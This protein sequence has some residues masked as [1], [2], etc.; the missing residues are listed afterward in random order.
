MKVIDYG[1]PVDGGISGRSVLTLAATAFQGVARLVANVAIGRLGDP[2]LLGMTQSAIASGNIGSLLFAS[3]ASAAA[4][5]NIAFERAKQERERAHAVAVHLSRRSVAASVVIGL[6]AASVQYFVTGDLVF[7][8]AVLVLCVTSSAYALSRGLHLGAGEIGRLATWEIGIATA[9]LIGTAALLLGGVRSIWVVAP[10][11]VGHV[12]MAAFAWPR[13][14]PKQ[15][16]RVDKRSIRTFVLLGTI[17]TLSSAGF[18]QLAIIW[19][20]GLNGPAYAGQMTAALSMVGPA[21]MVAGAISQVLFP[22]LAAHHGSQDTSGLA[23]R[24]DRST[25]YVS[26]VMVAMLCAIMPLAQPLFDVI[27]GAEFGA[28]VVIFYALAAGMVLNAAAGP[29]VSSITSRSNSGMAFSAISSALGFAVGVSSWI[30]IGAFDPELAV[31]IG[32]LIGVSVIAAVPYVRAWRELKMRWW[33]RT[34]RTM[35]G[36][37]AATGTSIALDAAG[38]PLYL[39]IATAVVLTAAWVFGNP[40]QVRQIIARLRPR[41]G[42]RPR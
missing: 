31:P 39:R 8:I 29:A 13:R 11:A 42:R 14:S 24:V 36:I 35:L 34:A 7:A 15:L 28:A 2:A 32:Y 3:S 26:V 5:R 1:R 40:A 10:I 18:I 37:L 9:A 23:G 4:S 17:G 22:T 25:A 38:A 16:S 6:L 12:A 19:S 33:S 30:V 21:T 41:T 27:W 20:N